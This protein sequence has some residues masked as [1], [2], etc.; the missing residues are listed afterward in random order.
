[1]KKLTK[2]KLINWHSYI[3]NT[4]DISNNTIICGENGSGKSTLLD[5]I[6]YVI[7]CG[8]CKFNTAAN[9]RNDRN[10]ES[11]VRGKLS[12]ENKKYLREGDVISHVA[13]EFFDDFT[14]KFY[15]VG[16]VIS[17]SAGSKL[18]KRFYF[19]NEEKIIEENFTK[20]S[21]NKI[22]PVSFGE[23]KENYLKNNNKIID[24]FS[25]TQE[26]NKIDLLS[27]LGLEKNESKKYLELLPKA[28]A[29]KPISDVN[30]FVYDYLLP[31]KELAL[32]NMKESVRRLSDIKG[33]ILLEESKLNGLEEIEYLSYGYE[34]KKILNEEMNSILLDREYSKIKEEKNKYTKDLET[35]NKDIDSLNARRLEIN[36]KKD[37]TAN[38]I[39]NLKNLEE[40]KVLV[41]LREKEEKTSSELLSYNK[42]DKENKDKIE[43]LSIYLNSINLVNSLKMYYYKED[44]KKI[45][46]EIFDIK[47]K[48]EEKYNNNV[49]DRN[50]LNSD[51]E[52]VNNKINILKKNKSEL[53]KG[54]KPYPEYTKN[55]KEILEEYFK[56]KYNRDI[57]VSVFSDLVKNVNKE[58][59]NALE[60]FLN[61][62]RFYLFVDEA[63]YD[64]AL[65]VYNEI[66]KNGNLNVYT[67]GLVATNTL[68]EINEDEINKDS[69]FAKMEYDS[70]YVRRYS[71]MI[72]NNVI[73][74][75][76]VDELKNHD[77]SITKDGML[78]QSHVARFINPNVYKTPYLGRDSIIVQLED[79]NEQLK[80]NEEIQSNLYESILIN[81]NESNFIKK[82]SSLIRDVE[83]KEDIFEKIKKLTNEITS[84]NDEMNKL[85]NSNFIKNQ[86]LIKEKETLLIS[87][88]EDEN[89]VISSLN[90]ASG[91]KINYE[92]KL[93]EIEQ[94]LSSEEFIKN[95]N[96][97]V[98]NKLKEQYRNK[99]NEEIEENIN[100]NN[101]EL[102]KTRK[103]I[104]S[105]MKNYCLNIDK[106]CDLDPSIENLNKFINIYND[107]KNREI[108]K[109][110]EKANKAQ[111]EAD[112]AFKN[113]YLTKIRSFIEDEKD[114][115]KKLNS[116]LK[117][118]NNKFGQELETYEFVIEGTEDAKLKP[119]YELLMSNED[120]NSIGLLSS[121]I[122]QKNRELMDDL[123][124][125]I[126]S[127][128]EKENEKELVKFL[129]YRNF[130]R[131][132]IKIIDRNNN[133]SYYSKGGKGK[134][135]GETQTPFYVFI[136][137]SFNQ[138]CAKSKFNK[139]NTPICLMFLDEA[140][141]NMDESR[142]ESMMNFYSK[143]NIQLLIS[144]PTQ[145]APSMLNHVETAL[146]V[147]KDKNITTIFDMKKV[148]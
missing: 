126:T 10:V 117:D 4:I 16:S 119:Y 146:G 77:I 21:G 27:S 70:E 18:D 22:S 133:I 107:I 73:C 138:I 47:E 19:I 112:I 64:E 1:M 62:R 43:E 144:V 87:L 69:L 74:V 52:F 61:T 29:F 128:D 118:P 100:K 40:D 9:E 145:R 104:E 93:N 67:A 134:S 102:E 35:L 65:R 6:N 37:E 75:D 39:N 137:A 92:A 147:I 30:K 31:E 51:Y 127:D 26:L 45:N 123:F 59:K 113:D 130:M 84:R 78:Y 88:K 95:I 57:K 14:N 103:E 89:D 116:I 20:K 83:L 97:N 110:K 8:T 11:Y 148:C 41:S 80:K 34:N 76:S 136:A 114:N 54:L 63:Y 111:E 60:G 121:P 28:L 2:I 120:F 48:L 58:R 53:E 91:K 66:A 132:D 125:R 32:D 44:Y 36:N 24:E 105:Y 42:K 124:K 3:N 141:N 55:L 122:S 38:D 94:K 23:L 109:Y 99:S 50:R 81:K 13:L 98:F 12:F 68:K 7:S 15:V 106:K 143:L 49:E 140:F 56:D 135:G 82:S 101:L 25:K 90:L 5:A 33:T 72:L 85:N 129:D 79:C 131:Y 86:E 139:M 96:T 46:E 142:I 71:F 115:I 17:Y 108:I